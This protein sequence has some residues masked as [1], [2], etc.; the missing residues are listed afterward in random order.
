MRDICILG[1]DLTEMTEVNICFWRNPKTPRPDFAARV[2][3][4]RS[5]VR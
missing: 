1:P 4:F 5:E 3:E 2:A